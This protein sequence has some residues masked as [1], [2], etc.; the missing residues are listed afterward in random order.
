MYVC[1]R[2]H[3]G[4]IMLHHQMTTSPATFL[5]A[6]AP[7][8]EDLVVAGDCILT[9]YWLAALCAQASAGKRDGT[10]GAQLGHAELTWAFSEAAG[11]LLRNHPVGQT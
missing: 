5:Q 8:R 6:I 7:D 4:E 11:L 10:S 2:N 3:E 1:I 9:W